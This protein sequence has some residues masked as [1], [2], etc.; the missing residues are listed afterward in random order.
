MPDFFKLV[1]SKSEKFKHVVVVD[2]WAKFS[3]GYHVHNVGASSTAPI[4][5]LIFVFAEWHTGDWAADGS[6]FTPTKQGC[7][8][9]GWWYAARSLTDGSNSGRRLMYGNIGS[10]RD[11]LLVLAWRPLSSCCA[12]VTHGA[13]SVMTKKPWTIRI[14][15]FT[16]LPREVVLAADGETVHV[17]PPAELEGL[18]AAGVPPTT[19]A[20]APLLCGMANRRHL[21]SVLR[22]AEFIVTLD[23]TA[24]ARGAT[25]GLYLW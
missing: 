5:R 23:V 2:P 17:R 25:A 22:A 11:P 8:D 18:R 19:A 1:N 7:L 6:S 24:L 12:D 16:A 15:F 13:N 21:S 9:Y 20:D 14:R 10:G 4:L 3:D